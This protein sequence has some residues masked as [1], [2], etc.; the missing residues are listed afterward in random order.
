MLFSPFSIISNFFKDKIDSNLAMYVLIQEDSMSFS[1]FEDSK[2]IFGEHIDMQNSIIE[3]E[4]LLE[5]DMELDLDDDTSLDESIDLDDINVDNVIE[6]IEDFSDI[7]DLDSIED[8]DE[9]S[10]TQDIEE[11]LHEIEEISEDV[12][13]EGFNEDYERF[14]FIQ[15]SL[16]SFYNDTKYESK[17]IENIYI[18]DAVGVSN[19]LK[20]YFEEEMFLNVYIRHLDLNVEVSN[21]AKMEIQL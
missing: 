1:I 4:R 14:S 5:E 18:A 8:I 17:F 2:L 15:T 21:L 13:E 11:E 20:H 16:S 19:E 6:D 10:K 12:A 3:D 9:F 7:E